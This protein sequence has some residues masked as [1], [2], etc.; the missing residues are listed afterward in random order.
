MTT[1]GLRRDDGWALQQL[2]ADITA[3]R[4]DIV[5]GLQDRPA[6]PLARRFCQ[7]R[8]DPRRAR[9]FLVSVMQQ[10]N[11]TTSMGRLTLNILLSFAQF[12]KPPARLASI[13]DGF[14]SRSELKAPRDR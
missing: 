14:L 7:N 1:A 11:T 4:V 3:R 2:L 13:E 9:C 6:D 10:F 12:A 5:V 8:R